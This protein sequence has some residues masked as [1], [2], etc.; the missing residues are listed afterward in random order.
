MFD[1]KCCISRR[2]AGRT[3]KI[4]EDDYYAW[5]F[6]MTISKTLKYSLRSDFSMINI[7]AIFYANSISIVLTPVWCFLSFPHPLVTYNAYF[8]WF[9]L[10][11]RGD[12][13]NKV[14]NCKSSLV[15]VLEGLPTF[16]HP[17]HVQGQ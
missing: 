16:L 14:A 17:Y 2:K 9:G 13:F 4:L 12:P 15:F 11:C 7:A 10:F 6:Q 5:S 1:V 3:V 8:V